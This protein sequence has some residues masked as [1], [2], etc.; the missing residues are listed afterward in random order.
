MIEYVLL[1][2]S[3]AFSAA[4]QPGPLQTFLISR[5]ASV[6]WKKTLPASFSPLIS[7]IPIALLVLL[8]IGQLSLMAQ[9]YL[10]LAGGM[11]LLY[12]AWLTIRQVRDS[13]AI[14]SD[15]HHSAPKSLLQAVV[16]NVLNPNPYIGWTLV[17]GPA[18]IRAWH[19]SPGNAVALV[20]AFYGTMVITL[21]AT[22]I[23]IGSASF[24]NARS[25][26]MLLGIS[27]LC[28]AGLGSYQFIVSISNIWMR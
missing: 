1:G 4:I 10:R 9:Q 3:F 19:H 5:V 24:L 17:L 13:S 21:G 28:L 18:T 26:R 7:D 27:G 12:L 6:G 23:L 11:L 22:I 14:T 8:V 25:Q 2:M 20:A 15:D 16:I